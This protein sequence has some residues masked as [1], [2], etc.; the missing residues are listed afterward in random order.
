[1]PHKMTIE[2]IYS[3]D[4][5]RH[6]DKIRLLSGFLGDFAEEEGVRDIHYADLT[7]LILIGWGKEHEEQ[8]PPLPPLPPDETPGPEVHLDMEQYQTRAATTAHY[9]RHDMS[10]DPI[11]I[12]YCVGKLNGEA[13]E[14]SEIFWK[15]QRANA[16]EDL[17]LVEL[18]AEAKRK[19]LDEAG[20]V[21]WYI[22]MIA[23][24][25]GVSLS[26][27]AAWNLEKLHER[28]KYGKDGWSESRKQQIL[29]SEY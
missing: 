2:V 26:Q 24:E 16:T 12:A 27:V 28:A 11:A 14:A 29:E 21:L 6:G 5:L 15:H 17:P 10:A 19:L 18:T 4:E 7:G 3:G 9:P 25:L 8:F 1:M 23:R 22:A 20:D 13:G